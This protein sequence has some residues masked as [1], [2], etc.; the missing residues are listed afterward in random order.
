VNPTYFKT[1][2]K[3]VMLYRDCLNE[4]GWIKRKDHFIKS[5]IP[6]IKDEIYQ[7]VKAQE[8]A[9]PEGTKL[10]QAARRLKMRK[11]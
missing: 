7:K 1:V 2:M 9:D 11:S 3:F 4:L 10:K 5:D 6:L 8:F